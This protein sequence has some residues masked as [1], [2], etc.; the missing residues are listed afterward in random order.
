MRVRLDGQEL[1]FAADEALVAHRQGT[2]WAKGPSTASEWKEGHVTGP[3]RDVFD[4]PLLFVYGASDP[5]EAALNERVAR[6]WAHVRGG[7]NVDYPVMSDREFRARGEKLDGDR[8]L[9][10]VGR[11]ETNELVR[12]LEPELPIRIE[13]KQVVVGDERLDGEQLGAAFVRPNPKRRDRYVV[14]VEGVDARA[15]LR[16][17]SLP[18]LLP[19]FAVYDA[20]V[21]PAR[22]QLL[23]NAGKLR[24]AGFFGADWS[25]P[26]RERRLD[27]LATT[28]RPGA[29]S[30]HDATPYL[31]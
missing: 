14:V 10:L 27:P 29:A 18:D 1:G 13:G 3:I 11:A 4:E 6:G 12:A 2:S 21:A 19:D 9:F 26:P 17:L 24:E 15:T 5:E 30:E 20:E 25:L 22:G 23:L 28:T 7:M 31:P 8:A 16:S